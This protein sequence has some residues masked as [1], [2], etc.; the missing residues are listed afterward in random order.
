MLNKKGLS[1]QIMTVLIITMV[2]VFIIIAFWVGSMI[3][4]LLTGTGGLLINQLSSSI[5]A[6]SP[7]TELANASNIAL[8]TAS[9][10]LGVVETIVYLVMIF[11]FLGFIA[12][13]YYVRTYPFLAFFW[14]F[15]LIGLVF[16][17]MIISNSYTLA[18]QN[19]TISGYY[20]TWGSNDF[21]MSNLPII[22]LVVGVV[23]GIFLFILASREP[24]AEAQP[25]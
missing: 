1:G 25:L 18:S 11:L 17:S 8:N 14:V 10:V 16:L 22:V 15:I 21:L 12:L 3:L 2:L 13:A 7:N 19:P 5:N 4:P 23:G 6:N 20:T 24:E 9:S